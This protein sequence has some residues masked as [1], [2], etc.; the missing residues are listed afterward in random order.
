MVANCVGNVLNALYTRH[1]VQFPHPIVTLPNPPYVYSDE[2]KVGIKANYDIVPDAWQRR[3]TLL[4]RER[5]LASIALDRSRANWVKSHIKTEI[6]LTRPK[7]AR[8]IQAS[9]T[10]RG[11]YEF[12]DEYRAF[13]EAMV[14]WS[15]IPRMYFGTFVHL[16]SACGLNRDA[17]AEQVT[18][19][20]ECYG[21]GA[22]Y[23]IDDVSNMDGSVQKAHLD[24]HYELYEFL[25]PVL[26]Q[27]ARASF[28]FKG[29]VPVRETLVM[30]TGCATVKSGAQDTSSGQTTRRLDCFVR[31]LY[32][33]G[34]THIIG[35][36]FGDDL[37]VILRGCLPTLVAMAQLQATCGWATKG[38]YVKTVEQA[39]FLASAF[40]PL[41]IGGYAM[42][43]LIGRLLA[44][45]FW[46]WRVIPPLRCGSYVH[47]VAEAFR[48]LYQG[49]RFVTMWLDWHLRIPQRKSFVW[50]DAP[51]MP[52][53]APCDWP[54]FIANRYGLE[55]PGD[56]A[57]PANHQDVVLMYHPWA[58]AVM[59]YDL[60]DP[61]ERILL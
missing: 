53:A 15:A 43:P 23:F 36:V 55:M 49:L 33:S 30:Y 60:T 9:L 5:I 24:P 38:V 8:L 50:R 18:E 12:A 42:R 7:K 61:Q 52:L 16:R 41:R 32:G 19:W 40:V 6:A 48:P 20:I 46:T 56:F 17:I 58:D 39:D 22:T 31:C 14:H 13:T 10:Q 4:Q 2:G 44:K 25:D 3:K 27:H 57:Y 1:L 29:L 47:Q 35:F 51:S 45:L 28:K 11:N 37:W 59:R 54:A 34:V 26:A 21:G